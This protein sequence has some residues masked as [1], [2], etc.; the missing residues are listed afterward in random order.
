MRVFTDIYNL[1]YEIHKPV[2]TIGTFDGLHLG[3]QK[4]LEKLKSVSDEKNCRNLVITFWPH[5][6]RVLSPPDD[7]P[8]LL[9][10]LE[11]KI[12]L[13]ENIGIDN[14]L[15]L[16]FT[17]EFSQQNYLEFIEDLLIKKIDVSAVVSGYDHRFGKD[18]QGSYQL[19]NQQHKQYNIEVFEVEPF[20]LDGIAVSSTKIRRFLIEGDIERANK[21]LGYHYFMDGKVI[22]GMNIG[23]KLD[24]PTANI[25]FEQDVQ[26]MPKDGVYL[27]KVEIDNEEFFGM[28]N[29][30]ENPT[31]HGKGRSVEVNIFDFSKNVYGKNIT[32]Y[33]L[34][35]LRDELKFNNLNEL[36]Q[37]MNA[38]REISLQKISQY[39]KN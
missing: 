29:S 7:M 25:D 33:F 9:S 38:D 23:S 2:V 4:V 31:I 22:K 6:R 26:Q 21:M 30:G 14:L 5:P 39:L 15:V 37:Q 3:H 32:V 34:E 24:F 17:V 18:R 1:K 8:K 35:R 12:Y 10:T 36:R 19:L 27:V 11:N 28:L 20:I 13:F 16:P